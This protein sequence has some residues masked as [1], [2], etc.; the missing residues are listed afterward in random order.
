MERYEMKYMFDWGGGIC[1]WSVNKK[2]VEDY[3]YPVSLERLPI[4]DDL[5]AYLEKLMDRYDEALNWDDPAGDLLWNEEEKEQFRQEATIGYERMRRE[6][7]ES[8]Y[9]IHFEVL[10]IS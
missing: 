2:A 7:P 10:I 1:V 4:S 5:K 6:L 3:D 9:L 8:E